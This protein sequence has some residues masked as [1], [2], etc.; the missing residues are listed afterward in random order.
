[1]ASPG[2]PRLL[3]A[4]EARG[5]ID[6]DRRAFPRCLAGG[7]CSPLPQVGHHDLWKA[8]PARALPPAPSNHGFYEHPVPQTWSRRGEGGSW[9]FYARG[10]P[11]TP[12]DCYNNVPWSGHRHPPPTPRSRGGRVTPAAAGLLGDPTVAY[13]ARK[14]PSLSSPLNGLK[15]TLR[16]GLTSRYGG[17]F[18]QRATSASPCGSPGRHT[19]RSGPRKN[20]L[21]RVSRLNQRF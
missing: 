11:G 16:P 3:D 6:A 9:L 15:A 7:F 19:G 2:C 12:L 17:E 8:P 5:K 10:P 1:V 4:I 13:P 14:P 18:R 20:P 21:T